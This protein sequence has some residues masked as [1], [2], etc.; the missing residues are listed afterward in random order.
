MLF[1]TFKAVFP[2]SR[3]FEKREDFFASSSP[4]LF[5]IFQNVNRASEAR[6]QIYLRTLTAATKEIASGRKKAIS[7]RRHGKEISTLIAI[8]LVAICSIA[9]QANWIFQINSILLIF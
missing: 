3:K 6:G 2:L 4:G 7:Y 9:S 1:P 5:W 8:V